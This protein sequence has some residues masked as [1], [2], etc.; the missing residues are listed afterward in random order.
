MK[1]KGRLS[2]PLRWYGGKYY[3]APKIVALISKLPHK[4]Y[5]EPYGGAAAVLLT[6][7][8]SPVEVW[9]DI[10][11]RLANFFAV[12]RD[13]ARRESL[14][15]TLALTP[16]SRGEFAACCE[17]DDEPED[18]HDRADSREPQHDLHHRRHDRTADRG[19]FPVLVV[20]ASTSPSATRSCCRRDLQTSPA[21]TPYT[22]TGAMNPL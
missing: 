7:T 6:K 10:D 3:H 15:E 12:L 18:Q 22:A 19:G 14:L 13:P 9:N 17:A 2:P 1:R 16:Y 4:T 11:G 21:R 8:P 20:H 5:V